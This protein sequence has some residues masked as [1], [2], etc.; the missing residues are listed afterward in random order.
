MDAYFHMM[1]QVTDCTI[2]K[3]NDNFGVGDL[4][5]SVLGDFLVDTQMVPRPAA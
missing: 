5:I 3:C 4:L 2:L 1:A